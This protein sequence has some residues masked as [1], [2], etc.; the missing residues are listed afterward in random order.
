MR[1]FQNKPASKQGPSKSPA[2]GSQAKPAAA[3]EAE[4]AP[5]E[6]VVNLDQSKQREFGTQPGVVL[7]RSKAKLKPKPKGKLYDVRV[8]R[9]TVQCP[10]PLL[11]RV[12]IQ[13]SAFPLGELPAP[14]LAL[15]LFWLP[16]GQAA[17]Q[18][19]VSRKFASA[20][21]DNV[22][23]KRRCMEDVKGIDVEQVFAAEKETS[24]TAFYKRH[25]V[26]TIRIVTVFR[27]SGGNSLSGDFQIECA[28]GV[29]VKAFLEKVASH[30]QN[31]QRGA[32]LLQP[33]DASKLG[34]AGPGMLI[35]KHPDAKPNCVFLQDNPYAA[36]AEAGL[37][38][39]AVLEQRERMMCD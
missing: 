32:P 6:F 25:T 23:W 18:A 7:G 31:R 5:G 12:T 19:V 17:R 9:R 37:C 10:A 38:D 34:R 33:H 24:W 8:L 15:V 21:R 11:Q 1:N 16:L 26:W 27:H 4:F 2:K 29:T 13:Q 3:E 30:P 35:S 39:G 28:P 14:A 20:F 22:S 36:L